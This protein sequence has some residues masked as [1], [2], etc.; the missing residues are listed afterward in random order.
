MLIKEWLSSKIIGACFEVHNELGP[1]LMEHVY[2]NALMR[3][4]N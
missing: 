3:D 4:W 1:G 2:E